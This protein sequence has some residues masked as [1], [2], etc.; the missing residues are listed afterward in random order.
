[1]SGEVLVTQFTEFHL[2]RVASLSDVITNPGPCLTQAY[3]YCNVKV[4]E[5]N[6]VFRIT[7]QDTTTRSLL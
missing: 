3:A 6:I 7:S 1:M 4:R 5:K 2:C